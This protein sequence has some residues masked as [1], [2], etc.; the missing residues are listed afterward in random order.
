MMEDLSR[1]LGESGEERIRAAFIMGQSGRVLSPSWSTPYLTEL[2]YRP[3][4][5]YLVAD[6]LP[7]QT[8]AAESDVIRR[9]EYI[10]EESAGDASSRTR[11]DDVEMD[12]GE[13]DLD[14]KARLREVSRQSLSS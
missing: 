14:G 8:A 4:V 13:E 10:L 1:L 2:L 6:D 12:L 9:L 7:L 11:E 3:F 5:A